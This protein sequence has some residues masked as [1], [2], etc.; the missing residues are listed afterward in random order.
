M[1][2]EEI[3]RKSVATKS[4]IGLDDIDSNNADISGK[5]VNELG[6]T[7]EIIQKDKK[8]FFTG[9]YT[10][11]VSA[12]GGST[13]GII[14]G[15][16]CGN[17]IVFLVNWDEYAAITSWVGQIDINSPFI[18]TT[19]PTTAKNSF[20]EKIT[21]LWMMTSRPEDIKDEWASINSGT[22]TFHRINK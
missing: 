7:I 21:T 14:T 22:D 3:I 8:P 12:E 10:S 18:V 16:I 17:L 13:T 15:T 6:S 9:K 11:A 19:E 20:P 4:M 5:W 1:L 2:L